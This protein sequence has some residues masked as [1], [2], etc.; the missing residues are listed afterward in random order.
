MMFSQILGQL[1]MATL[2][3]LGAI[4]IHE[5]SHYQKAVSLGYKPRYKNFTVIIDEPVSTMDEKK[6]LSAGVITGLIFIGVSGWLTLAFWIP[7]IIMYYL[8]CKHDFKRMRK[9]R[10]I[11]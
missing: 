5:M 4:L 10:K 7:I 8:G 2:I 11:R 9:L 6:I 3:F 1:F